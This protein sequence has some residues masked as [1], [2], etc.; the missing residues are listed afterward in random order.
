MKMTLGATE[1]LVKAVKMPAGE[2]ERSFVVKLILDAGRTVVGHET[3]RYWWE[4]IVVAA[5]DA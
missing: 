5:A 3:A 4:K 1:S 2:P